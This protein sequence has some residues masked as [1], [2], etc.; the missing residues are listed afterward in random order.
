[1]LNLNSSYQKVI[2]SDN[3]FVVTQVGGG[4][5]H[6]SPPAFPVQQANQSAGLGH[7]AHP[8][9]PTRRGAGQRQAP[10]PHLAA[11]AAAGQPASPA[12]APCREQPSQRSPGRRP[13]A[14]RSRAS[15]T[16]RNRKSPLLPTAPGGCL[17]TL[18]ERAPRW[19]CVLTH[20]RVFF[21]VLSTHASWLV[22]SIRAPRKWSAPSTEAAGHP[23]RR[24]RPNR[25]RLAFPMNKQHDHTLARHRAK[26]A[27]AF[28]TLPASTREKKIKR[29]SLAKVPF[30]VRERGERETARERRRKPK[31]R[32]IE[33]TRRT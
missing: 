22:V 9:Q 10:G 6:E 25:H 3:Q 21:F 8:G 1:M 15:V 13:A 12:A 23:R 18:A 29:H 24:R 14:P 2:A 20:G 7:A 5:Q 4:G 28:Q 33:T 17:V 16:G 31:E 30:G 27:R 19:H 26:K 11:R 32:Q